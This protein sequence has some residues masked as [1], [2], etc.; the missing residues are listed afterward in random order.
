MEAIE[1]KRERCLLELDILKN[2]N[3][4]LNLII[5]SIYVFSINIVLNNIILI[6]VILYNYIV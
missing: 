4:T 5:M 2:I 1:L 6:L 3:L